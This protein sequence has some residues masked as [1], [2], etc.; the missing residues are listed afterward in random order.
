MTP[1]TPQGKHTAGTWIRWLVLPLLLGTATV[2]LVSMTEK[3]EREIAVAVT[4][5][6]LADD[7]LLMDAPQNTTRLLVSGAPS[8]LDSMDPRETFCR[9]DLSGLGEGTHT[10][11]VRPENIGLPKEVSLSALLT[12]QL[13]IR[14]ET[15]SR[16]TVRV[17]AVLDEKP[18]PGHTVATVTL[19]PDRVVLKGPAAMLA[20]I[21][22]V[23]TRPI[24]LSAAMES[25]KKEV[26]LNLPADIA[27]DPPLR[28]VV[29]EVKV[30]ERI[31]TRVLENMP[32][33]GK[34][35]SA[36]FRI[37]PEAIALTV[38]GP[39]AIVNTIE[40]NPAFA[41]T[42][43]LSGLSPGDHTLKAAIGLPVRTA[44]VRVSPERFSVTISK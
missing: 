12:P 3:Q 24:N 14:L 38:S 37:R 44:L 39:A 19:R 10:V 15:V 2:A 29:A 41:V 16:K 25:F 21:D 40:T 11:P 7:L 20:K 30:T 4:F 28:I 1:S 8:A 5:N 43:D 22:T 26:P 42:I 13:T 31:I 23:K 32:V 27:V 18:A 17:M 35:T 9:L 33:S 6:N 34:G 36:G